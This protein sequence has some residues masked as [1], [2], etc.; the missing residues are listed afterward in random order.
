MQGDKSDFVHGENSAAKLST[1]RTNLAESGE[2]SRFTDGAAKS[3]PG[4]SFALVLPTESDFASACPR[5][6]C[7]GCGA[8]RALV[9]MASCDRGQSNYIPTRHH[10]RGDLFVAGYKLHLCK[11]HFQIDCFCVLEVLSTQSVSEMLSFDNVCRK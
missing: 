11:S 5:W 4:I 9:C 3:A 6:H 10:T 7:G 8:R 2:S 1:A